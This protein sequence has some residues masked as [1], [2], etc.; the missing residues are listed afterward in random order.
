MAKKGGGVPIKTG[1]SGS[2]GVPAGGGNGVGKQGMP[3]NVQN[4]GTVPS[5]ASKYDPNF[6]HRIK[7]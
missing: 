4:V 6:G 3:S 1:G 7:K 2:S 5:D